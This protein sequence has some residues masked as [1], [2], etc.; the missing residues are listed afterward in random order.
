MPLEH[1]KCHQYVKLSSLKGA[2]GSPSQRA[3][4]TGTQIASLFRVLSTTTAYTAKF[5]ITGRPQFTIILLWGLSQKTLQ[6]L[7]K[8]SNARRN[9]PSVV[10]AVSMLLPLLRLQEHQSGLGV[11]GPVFLN[12]SSTNRLNNEYES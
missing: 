9:K 12:S 2:E 1:L 10:F 3:Y 4:P 5:P 7:G 11:L 6:F 8:S